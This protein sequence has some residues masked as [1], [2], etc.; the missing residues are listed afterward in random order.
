MS[1]KTEKARELEEQEKTETLVCES[2][3]QQ[4]VNSPELGD[5]EGAGPQKD[6]PLTIPAPPVLYKKR[7]LLPGSSDPFSGFEEGSNDSL[8]DMVSDAV[9]VPVEQVSPEFKKGAITDDEVKKV[10]G[11]LGRNFD[12]NNKTVMVAVFLLFLKRSCK[13]RDPSKFICF[14]PRK[15]NFKKRSHECVQSGNRQSIY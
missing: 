10:I 11:I 12:L 3:K 15:R 2:E 7:P 6:K 14:G 1:K 4:G 5:S 8:E 13:F 9:Y